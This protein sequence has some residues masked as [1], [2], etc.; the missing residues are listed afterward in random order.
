MQPAASAVL[1]L[2]FEIRRDPVTEAAE[3]GIS[4]LLTR[5]LP[6]LGAESPELFSRAADGPSDTRVSCIGRAV[7]KDAEAGRQA[8]ASEGFQLRLAALAAKGLDVYATG[9]LYRQWADPE[10]R[11]NPSAEGTLPVVVGYGFTR[12][13]KSEAAADQLPHDWVW[14]QTYL[15]GCEGFRFSALYEAVDAKVA[16][17]PFL[18]VAAWSGVG[19]LEAAM[20][21]PDAG[22]A[23]PHFSYTSSLGVVTQPFDLG[24]SRPRGADRLVVDVSDVVAAAA[25]AAA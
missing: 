24:A 1:F 19:H 20:A 13:R 18:S 12:A 23:H 17:F 16:P 9:G 14:S 22:H 5:F 4:E 7:F 2:W 3:D 25:P 10:V 6:S 11:G 15:K 8:L 21:G